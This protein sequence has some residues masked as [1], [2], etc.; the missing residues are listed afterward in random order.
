MSLHARDRNEGESAHSEKP[1]ARRP[2][3]PRRTQT[4]RMVRPC[5]QSGDGLRSTKPIGISLRTIQIGSVLG[6][7]RGS[8]N[9]SPKK[10]RETSLNL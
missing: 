2:E 1:S 8:Q 7:K 9:D 6:Q 3:S 10:E 5:Y 4:R